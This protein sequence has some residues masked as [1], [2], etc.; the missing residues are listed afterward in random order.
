MKVPK[1]MTKLVDRLSQSRFV[2][3]VWARMTAGSHGWLTPGVVSYLD[4]YYLKNTA[5][6]QMLVEKLTQDEL[7]RLNGCGGGTEEI[8][9]KLT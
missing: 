9:P 1:Q 7:E 4:E 3:R 2:E 6:I 5:F 8:L